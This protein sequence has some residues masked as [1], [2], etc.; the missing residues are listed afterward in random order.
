[1]TLYLKDATFV[2]WEDLTISRTNLG[3][4]AGQL[5]IVAVVFPIAALVR[6]TTLYR[7]L[8]VRWWLGGGSPHRHRLDGR[9]DLRC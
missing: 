8:G 5:A 2:D 9:T 4:E 3:V 7:N 1:M 6:R